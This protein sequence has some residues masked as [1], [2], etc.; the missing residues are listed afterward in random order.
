[1]SQTIKSARDQIVSLFTTGTL[2]NATL[3][4]VGVGAVYDCEPTSYSSRLAVTVQ[5]SSVTPTAYNIRVRA[6][7]QVISADGDAQLG[8]N[9]ILDT[10]NALDTLTK[11][12]AYQG[13]SSWDISFD[14]DTGAYVA[15]TTLEVPRDTF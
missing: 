9:E 10:V 6:Y 12:S 13:P 7:R 5:G 1:M 11:S 8:H 4:A 3:A 2:P 15:E 14:L